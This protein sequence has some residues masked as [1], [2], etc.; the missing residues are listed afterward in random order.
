MALEYSTI[1]T[2]LYYA[3]EATA[4]SKPSSGWTEIQN[5]VSLAE[6]NGEPETIEVTNLVD[7][8]HRVIPGLL[9]E[10]DSY[11][12]TANFTQAFQTTWETLCSSAAT[13]KASGKST[14][15]ECVLPG[16]SKTWQFAGTPQTLGFP[17]ANVAEAQQIVA[18]ISKEQIDGWSTAISH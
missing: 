16:H 2:K 5:V 17:G 6:D 1:G 13:A 4:G 11:Q 10:A 18:Y 9:G 12:V 3:I 7:T 8:R 15:F 14:W